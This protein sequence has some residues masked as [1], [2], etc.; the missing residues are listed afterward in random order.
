M[1]AIGINAMTE[2]TPTQ[3]KTGAPLTDT[4]P[5][6][7]VVV[8]GQGEVFSTAIEQIAKNHF[9][10]LMEE[11]PD[12]GPFTVERYVP[13]STLTATQEALTSMTAERNGL[14][15]ALEIA[16]D[17]LRHALKRAEKAEAALAFC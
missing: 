5:T 14:N 8:C 12:L 13:L 10:S 9:Q 6:L 3:E 7:Y 11:F 1:G 2:K 15:L 16:D 4:I 17:G